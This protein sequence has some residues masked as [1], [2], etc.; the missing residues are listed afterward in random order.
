MHSPPVK[1]GG[2]DRMTQKCRLPREESRHL[3]D[4]L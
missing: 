4:D 3:R 2:V 1:V